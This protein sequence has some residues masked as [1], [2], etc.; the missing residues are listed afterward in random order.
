MSKTRMLFAQSTNIKAYNMDK[1]TSMLCGSAA[2]AKISNGTSCMN[3]ALLVQRSD[4][5][6]RDRSA[7]CAQPPSHLGLWHP[8]D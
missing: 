3:R 4:A 1:N 8:L 7:R 5:G 2:I 6:G